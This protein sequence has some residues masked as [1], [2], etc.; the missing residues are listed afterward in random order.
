MRAAEDNTAKRCADAGILPRANPRKVD[1]RKIPPF[2][3]RKTGY[4]YYGRG[5]YCLIQE[6]SSL[7]VGFLPCMKIPTR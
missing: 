4:Q 5:A 6:S 7:N 2:E 1:K 3:N